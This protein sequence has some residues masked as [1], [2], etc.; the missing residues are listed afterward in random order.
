M[1]NDWKIWKMIGKMAP[2]IGKMAKFID[3]DNLPKL[4]KTQI[5]YTDQ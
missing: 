2:M 4:K 3:K 1:T 5:T